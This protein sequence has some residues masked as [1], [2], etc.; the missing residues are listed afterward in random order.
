VCEVCGL[1]VPTLNKIETI[2]KN[3]LESK[4]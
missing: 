2:V 4:M 3:H 1:S